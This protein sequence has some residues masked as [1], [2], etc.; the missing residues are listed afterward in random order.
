MLPSI[1]LAT[2]V[3]HFVLLYSRDELYYW[4]TAQSCGTIER[5]SMA[6]RAV[7]ADPGA[8]QVQGLRWSPR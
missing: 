5:T 3:L 8:V 2:F 4:L 6:Q 7:S 1:I